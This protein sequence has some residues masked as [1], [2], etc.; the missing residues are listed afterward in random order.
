MKISLLALV[1]IL[2]FAIQSHAAVAVSKYS[3]LEDKDCNLMSSSADDAEAEIDYFKSVCPGQ[4]GYLVKFAGGDIRSWVGILKP[5]EKYDEAADFYQQLMQGAKGQFPN[6]QGNKLEW[7]YNDGKLV[8]FI[9]RMTAQ[10]PEVEGKDLENL[11]VV[12]VSSS[13]FSKACLI[14]SVDTKTVV[15]SNVAAQAIADD[16]SKQCP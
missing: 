2:G 11:V 10:D 15:N 6:V 5:G 14:G 8:A 9:L 13:D 12:R 4:D 16:A 3:S 7:R 1:M